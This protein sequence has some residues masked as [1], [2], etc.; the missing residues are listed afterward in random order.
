[1][2]ETLSMRER[3]ARAIDSEAFRLPKINL[4]RA[5][6]E[7]AYEAAD[8]VLEAMREPTCALAEAGC[9]GIWAAMDQYDHIDS[10]AVAAKNAWRRMIDEAI[11][12]GKDT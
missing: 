9:E 8:R 7:R 4:H 12:E 11:R 5:R 3:I 1:M 10:G 2:T 6:F